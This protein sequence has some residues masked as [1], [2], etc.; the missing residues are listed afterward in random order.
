MNEEVGQLI[1]QRRGE[2]GLSQSDLAM[3]AAVSRGTIKN[4]ERGARSMARDTLRRLE[5]ALGWADGTISE[6]HLPDGTVRKGY[7][8]PTLV[9]SA[10]SVD[11]VANVLFRLITTSN[12]LDDG[13][14]LFHDVM[15]ALRPGRG[16]PDLQLLREFR[17]QVLSQMPMSAT[18]KIID[19]LL[20]Y[21]QRVGLDG[22]A[23]A[24]ALQGG[25]PDAT[26]ADDGTVGEQAGTEASA[27]DLG[28]FAP[29]RRGPGGTRYMLNDLAG[30]GQ[31]TNILAVSAT[32]LPTNPNIKF[33][34]LL[35]QAPDDD[36]SLTKDDAGIYTEAT[37]QAEQ[38]IKRRGAEL[39]LLEEDLMRVKQ[40]HESG[41][42]LQKI[43]EEM[44]LD[45]KSVW[46]MLQMASG[47]GKQRPI[48]P[49]SQD[50]DG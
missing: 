34:T 42:P 4:A 18:R 27:E 49:P 6:A 44:E 7:D 25:E 35:L 39:F 30:L 12:E 37:E 19:D 41:M 47:F 3:L 28:V 22:A 29:P 26:E 33:V 2:I 10:E 43:A 14:T 38:A 17:A 15:K 32:P 36:A 46:E 20:D 8:P 24:I 23:A 1:K 9:L 45:L 48:A 31:I 40:L 50:E 11:A 21:M 16:Q 5:H 13:L